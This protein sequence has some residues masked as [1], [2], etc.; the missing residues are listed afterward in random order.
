MSPVY[1]KIKVLPNAKVNQIEMQPN[2]MICRLKEKAMDGKAN[3][4]LIRYLSEVLDVPQRCVSVVRGEKS[5]E[6]VISIETLSEA[7]IEERL[8]G[9]QTR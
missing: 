8:H 9:V 1:R 6:K 2:R 4:A 3:Q 5:R 7:E